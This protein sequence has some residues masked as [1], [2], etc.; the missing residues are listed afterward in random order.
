MRENLGTHTSFQKQR[1]REWLNCLKAYPK[2]SRETREATSQSI[3]STEAR[4]E[5]KKVIL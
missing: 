2:L 5:K 3:R 1:I 4:P